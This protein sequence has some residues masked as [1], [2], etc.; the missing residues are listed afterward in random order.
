MCWCDRWSRAVAGTVG[1]SVG[2][3]S[4]G[5]G[6]DWSWVGPWVVVGVDDVQGWAVVAEV[7]EDGSGG[8]AGDLGQF[9]QLGH[10]WQGTVTVVVAAGLLAG[11]VTGRRGAARGCG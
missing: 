7:F 10:C 8:A 11:T 1:W 3:V 6:W 2:W 9:H 5:W 4:V